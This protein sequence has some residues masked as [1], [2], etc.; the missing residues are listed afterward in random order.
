[1]YLT[2]AVKRA[3]QI[4]GGGI[5]SICADRTRTWAEFQERIARLASALHGLGCG[6]NDRAAVLALN[7]DRYFEFFYGVPWAG[8]VFVPINIRLAPPEVEFWLNDSGSRVLM[9]DD[10]FLPTVRALEGKLE[11]V[12]HVVYIG[13]GET[14]EGLLSYESLL[15]AAEP[16]ADAARGYDDLAGLFY[17]GGTTGRSK[18]VMLSHR[19]LVMNSF[20]VLPTFQFQP[21]MRWLHAAPMFHIADGCATFGVTTVAGTHVFIPAFSPDGTLDAVQRHGVTDTLLVPTMVNMLVNSPN[22]G[23]FDLSTLRSIV[24]GA[25]PMPEAV[26]VKAMDVMPDCGFTHAYG[27]TECA[28]LVTATGPEFHVLEGPH[29]GRFKSAGRAVAGVELKIADED[30]KEV[31]RGEIGEVCSRG[32]HVMQGYWQRPDLTA[33][34]VKD[35]WMHSGDAGYM[36]EEGFIYIVDR[37]KDMIIS[38]G[39]NIYSAEVENALYQHEAVVE[40]AVIGIPNDKWGEAVH[41]VVRLHEGQEASEE[42]LIAHCRELIAGFKCPR[43]V[44]FRGEPMPLSGAGKILKTDLRTPFWEGRDKAVN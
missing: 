3:V 8:C 42:A 15:A 1:M 25:S 4:N 12:E 17:T 31:P 5:A 22:V 10:Q 26:I 37:V 2:Q 32:P 36:D 34:A 35:G 14:P 11:T 39:E 6:D 23:E 30:G 33:E 27:Q 44:S 18:G 16:V 29:A 41:A 9:V 43:S 28:P 7:S 20:N 13:D 21:D 40:C 19:N 24:Y 38:G